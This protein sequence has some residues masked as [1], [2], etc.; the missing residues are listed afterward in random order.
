[1]SASGRRAD[2]RGSKFVVAAA[3]SMKNVR[4]TVPVEQFRLLVVTFVRAED[5]RLEPVAFQIE[6]RFE[7]DAVALSVPDRQRVQIEETLGHRS[8]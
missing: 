3:R 2:R 5:N 8:R 1:M 7:R 4:P 6:Q